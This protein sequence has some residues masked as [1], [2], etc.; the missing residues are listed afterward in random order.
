MEEISYDHREHIETHPNQK[1]KVTT[2]VK[3]QKRKIITNPDIEARKNLKKF[4]IVEDNQK[5]VIEGSIALDDKEIFLLP[6]GQEKNEESISKFVTLKNYRDKTDQLK[7]KEEDLKRGKIEDTKPRQFVYSENA[8]VSI[9]VSNIPFNISQEELEDFFNE[10]IRPRKVYRP[11][12]KENKQV[13]DFA[14][15]HYNTQEEAKAA[16]L[17]FNNK[18]CGDQLLTA[19]MAENRS[20]NRPSKPFIRK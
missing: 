7:R 14:L 10:G 2:V 18:R 11:V 20:F 17:R 3:I 6:F 13:R 15:V 1:F 8:S 19:E 9:K 12:S 16:I 4:G 5:G